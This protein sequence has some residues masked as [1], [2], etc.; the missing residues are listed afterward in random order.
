MKLGK[1]S[2]T[3]NLGDT[4]FRRKSLIEDYRILLSCLQSINVEF[5]KWDE[6]SQKEFYKRLL[7]YPDLFSRDK[8][9]ENSF[10]QRGRTAT[11]ALVKLGLTDENRNL[12][13]VAKNWLLDKNKTVDDIE[14]AFGIDMN[15]LL[16]LRQLLKLRVYAQDG[17]HYFYPFRFT[18]KLL[19][20]YSDIPQEDFLTLVH[21]IKST[22][23][24]DMIDDIVNDYGQVANNNSTFYEL[25]EKYFPEENSNLEVINLES[26]FNT[27]PLDKEVF[28]LLFVNRKSSRIREVYY[29]FVDALLVFKKEKT[30]VALDKLLTISKQDA[31]K[32]AFGFGKK[33]F[34]EAKFVSDFYEKNPEHL[35]LDSD[36]RNIYSQ[37][38][39]SKKRDIIR[40]YKDMTK[41]TF[42]LTGILDFS[43]GLVNAT[44]QQLF[45]IV[46]S[47]LTIVGKENILDY[48][49]ALSTEFYQERTLIEIIGLNAIDE[50]DKI[51]A[52]FGI[53]EIDQLEKV[54]KFRKEEKFRKFIK[55]NFPKEKILEI[56]PL[57]SVRN[58][59]LIHERVTDIAT[60]PTIFEYII[61]ITWYYISTE[62]FFLTES[63]NLTLDGNFRP[64]SHAAGGA[65]D[66][67]IDYQKLTLML[68]VTLMN[69][70]AQ[71]RGEW[72]PV[73][74][75]ATNLT[76]DKYPKNVTTLFIAD[77]LD[78]NTVNIWRA[79]ASVPLKH[80]SKDE[81]AELVKIFP[82]TISELITIL[83][84]ELNEQKLFAKIDA[85]YSAYANQFNLAWRDEIMYE[86]EGSIATTEHHSF[87][88][89]GVII[90]N[91]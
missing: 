60:I 44:N 63:L 31:I 21:L 72:E 61:A 26:I 16:F 25:I 32:K 47:N 7:T 87:E 68:E 66:I 90:D 6:F 41:R 43:N 88:N 11:N 89:N 56:L 39:L 59:K 51:K 30:D 71:K 35:L 83:E 75:H 3:Y 9:N 70:Q 37:F 14:K 57:F 81:Y 67:V 24:E 50:L 10:A 64:L 91:K 42:N 55:K 15:N 62:E 20:L 48:E 5:P 12:S 79:V 46:F 77:E 8:E 23:T 40:E 17:K 76:V 27:Y 82:L 53:M 2:V 49:R 58:D 29:Q 36:N 34:Q 85:S 19:S 80:S 65:G 78:D 45:Q 86:L 13:L 4:S 33:V 54:V 1:S 38:I 18:L 28:N 52:I 73:L 22:F 69:R 84:N 74:R